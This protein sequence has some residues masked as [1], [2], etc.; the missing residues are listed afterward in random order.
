MKLKQLVGAQ[1]QSGISPTLVIAEL[2]FINTGRKSFDN[3][4]NLATP[5]IMALYV[6]QQRDHAE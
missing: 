4:A 5:K 3:R 6:F 2:D 1:G